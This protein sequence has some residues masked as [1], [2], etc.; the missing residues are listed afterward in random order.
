MRND[1]RSGGRRVTDEDD[2]A[3]VIEVEDPA[4]RIPFPEPYASADGIVFRDPSKTVD[5]PSG[6]P[7]DHFYFDGRPDANPEL[8]PDQITL[9]VYGEDAETYRVEGTDKIEDH[10]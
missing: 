5:M 8:A 3:G 7:V 1:G 2:V 9:K 6:A 4:G 10:E